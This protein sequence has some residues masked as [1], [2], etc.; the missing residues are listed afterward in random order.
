MI[1]LPT[2]TINGTKL[3]VWGKGE[4][5]LSHVRIMQVN[6]VGYTEWSV[7]SNQHVSD[8]FTTLKDAVKFATELIG[9]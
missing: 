5:R 3:T 6:R 1:K 8:Y 4:Y 7:N 2:R 9:A